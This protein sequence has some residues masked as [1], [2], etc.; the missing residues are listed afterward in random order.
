MLCIRLLRNFVELEIFE[1][2]YSKHSDYQDASSKRKFLSESYKPM[3]DWTVKNWNDQVIALGIQQ[4]KLAEFDIVEMI[5]KLYVQ[6]EDPEIERELILLATTLL[7]EG[8]EV[9]QRKFMEVRQIG[10]THG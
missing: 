8:N 9:V 6:S 5:C 3:I 4:E 2:I 1:L 10:E 7:Y